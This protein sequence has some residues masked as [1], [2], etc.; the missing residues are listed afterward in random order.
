LDPKWREEKKNFAARQAGDNYAEVTNVG[1]NLDQMARRRRDIF[2]DEEEEGASSSGPGH[3]E[4]LQKAVQA[5]LYRVGQPVPKP[6]GNDD[7]DDDDNAPAAKQQPAAAAKAAPA[8]VA[9]APTPQSLAAAASRPPMPPMMPAVQRPPNAPISGTSVSAPASVPPGLPNIPIGIPS[10]PPMLPGGMAAPPGAPL[11]NMRGEVISSGGIP[12]MH[13]FPP[14]PGVL[15]MMMSA[16]PGMMMP[17]QGIPQALG[18]TAAGDDLGKRGRESGDLLSAEDFLLQYPGD[19]T[20]RS[21]VVLWD[22]LV[23]RSI[24]VCAGSRALSRR[25]GVGAMDTAGPSVESH[26]GPYN[27]RSSAFPGVSFSP[28]LVS[29]QHLNMTFLL[30]PPSYSCNRMSKSSSK[31]PPSCQLTSRS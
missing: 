16:P 18:P 29:F 26:N 31:A 10:M 30:M 7:S 8:P 27:D 2:G 28:V 19:V 3:K 17:Q 22:S 5:G 11:V 13:G 9:Q 12:G 25:A 14:Q 23:P 4:A 1:Q 20:V 21:G 15:G 6:V 24:R